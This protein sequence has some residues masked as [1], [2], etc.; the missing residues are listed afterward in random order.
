MELRSVTLDD[1]YTSDSGHIY[2]S[3]IQAVV[4]LC[5]MRRQRDRAS[6]LN[7]AGFVSGYPGSPLAALD[8][9]FERAR[10]HLERHQIHF[11]PGLSEDLAMTSIWGSQQINLFPDA[12]YDGVFGLW[13]GK[14]PGLDRSGDVFMHGNAAGTS[15]HGGVILV[16]GDDHEARTTTTA[17]QSEVVLASAFIPTLSPANVQEFLDYGLHGWAMS[18]F[19]GLWIGFKAV[20]ENIESSA[21]VDA[22]PS[23]TVEI[24]PDLP[25]MPP[26]GL[27]AHWPSPVA[28]Q[29]VLLKEF[30]L[31]A[32][33]AYVQANELDR[34][35][36]DCERARLGVVTAGK[37][38][39]DVME[40]LDLLSLDRQECARIGLRVYKVAMPWP[41]E[42]SGIERFVRGLEEILV[43]EEKRPVIEGQ[44]KDQFYNRPASQRPRIL[45]KYEGQGKWQQPGNWLLSSVGELSPPKIA[46]VLWD[47]ISRFHDDREVDARLSC[48]LERERARERAKNQP[49]LV[50]S[51]GLM[52]K[53]RL[54]Y[55]CSGCPHNTSTK[56]P[57]G[58]RA[59]AGIGCH[60]MAMWMDRQTMTFAQMGGEGV[61]WIGQAPFSNAPH[62]FA[63]LGDG[64][65]FHSGSLAIRACRAAGVNITFKILYNDAIA[66]T[67]GQS[68]PGLVSVPRLTRQLRDEGVG[69]V[70]VVTDE[71]GK[72]PTGDPIP[73]GVA[74]Y[75]RDELPRLQSE[76]RKLPGVSAIVY[77]QTCATEKRRRRKRGAYP[78]PPR[79]AFINHAVCEGCGDCSKASNCLSIMPRETEFGLKRRINQSTC[80]KDFSCLNGFCP[81]F[82]TVEGGRLR[83]KRSPLKN[84]GTWPELPSPELPRLRQPYGICVAGVG[85][86]GVVTIAAVVGMA[87]HLERKEVSVLDMT[88]LAQMGGAVVSQIRISDPQAPIHAARLPLVAEAVIG[89]D[90]AVAC[91]ELT[92]GLM[93]PRVTR[94]VINN[95]ASAT[96][97][98]TSDPDFRYP[99]QLM[100]QRIQEATGQ[101]GASFV[102]ATDLAEG[103][104]GDSIYANFFMLG[105]A[106]QRGLIPLGE[107]ALLQAIELNGTAVTQNT[108][109]FLWGRRSAED[110]DGVR[111]AAGVG[112]VGSAGP[113]EPLAERC[114]AILRAYQNEAYARRYRELVDTAREAERGLDNADT[115]FSEAVARYAFKLMAFKDEYEVARL[116][117]NG[118]FARELRETFEGRYKLNF[119]LA[120]PFLS[121]PDP[122]TGIA[123]KRRFGPWVFHAMRVLA[124]FKFLRGTPFDVFGYTRERKAERALF[125]SYRRDILAL[126]AALNADNY[127]LAVEIAV[128]PEKIRGF[129]HVKSRNMKQAEELRRRLLNEFWGNDCRTSRAA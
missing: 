27:N 109:A 13:Y 34:C 25:D 51:D 44:L 66:M 96:G 32:A 100:E 7:T 98:F 74:V 97:E 62:V 84:P 102:A 15:K 75:H 10:K 78:D 33:Q 11:Q 9:T 113:A 14:G 122:A 39:L 87:A 79:R 50:G 30:R 70:A 6:G 86:T 85:G 99:V 118:D 3:G 47:R 80:N 92:L 123:K 95:C 81:S 120:P 60:F 76:F 48:I 90:I 116:H 54:P 53:G 17:H 124:R 121:K 73:T 52:T 82:V 35:V 77:D 65:Y 40:A 125:A 114:A 26:E 46:A 103:L 110:I 31:P 89:T 29:E 12:R 93:E 1:K 38:Y 42:P 119:Y 18:R 45:G 67:G 59:L 68:V 88:G 41:L 61:P 101:D 21:S 43:V 58:S 72:Y 127:R 117:T 106:F 20:C 55:Y 126:A 37:A 57:E 112:G 129:G 64:T 128:I 105:H 56:V 8:L 83:Q 28:R 16:V 104:L 91:E 71:P 69:H 24:L 115:A 108:E 107:Q 2:L 23:R 94:A 19:S 4:R 111:K 22:S 49:P 5:M 36:I 63:N